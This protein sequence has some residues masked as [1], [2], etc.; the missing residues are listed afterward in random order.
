MPFYRTPRVSDKAIEFIRRAILNG[1]STKMDR[2]RGWPSLHGIHA[3]PGIA[4]ERLADQRR[5]DR[6]RYRHGNDHQQDLAEHA[7][8]VALRRRLRLSVVGL[9]SPSASAGS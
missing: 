5:A 6:D 3:P 4:R 7:A 8:F 2:A 9:V 1:S